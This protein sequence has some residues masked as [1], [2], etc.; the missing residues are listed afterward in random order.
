MHRQS[1]KWLAAL[2]VTLS[3]SL[4]G[5]SCGKVADDRANAISPACKDVATTLE[6][7]A[8]ANYGTF[9]VV[10]EFANSVAQDPAL[11]DRM[12]QRIIRADEVAKPVAD[13][14]YGALREY[15]KIRAEVQAGKST[16]EKLLIATANL[17][18]WVTQAA[19]LIRGLVDAVN[20]AT[21]E[22]SR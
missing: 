7:C 5:A 4:M 6:V 3:L 14:L 11:P 1:F 22:A 19:P 15:T 9:V 10:E 16:E 8:Y 12:R 2:V 20:D 18:K 13:S 21:K 17:N